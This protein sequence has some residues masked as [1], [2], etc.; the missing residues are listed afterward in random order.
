MST[1]PIYQA[2]LTET[3]RRKLKSGASHLDIG[4]GSG[5]LIQLLQQEC[6]VKSRSCDYTRE[7]MK[8]PG[9]E[10]DIANLNNDPLPYADNT[11]D[12]ITCT[13]VVEHLER[14][15]F[16]VREI[17]RVAKPGGLVIFSTPNILNLR[18]R[19]RFF[20][21][22][23]WNLFGPLPLH[24]NRLDTTGGHINPVSWFYLAHAM[25]DAGLVDVSWSI[26][27]CQRSSYL[28]F[29]LL[30]PLILLGGAWAMYSEETRYNTLDAANEPLVKAI[31]HP[32]MLLGRTILASG[33][34]KSV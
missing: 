17:V 2:V 5:T 14:F 9:I 32:K 3:R 13:E 29:S 30:Y 15:R 19:I 34:K 10:V 8:L 23:F 1:Q 24:H 31:N 27:R 6:G 11:F 4:S 7:L 25:M 21:F 20:C 12:L 33:V 18:S 22:G 26:D 16:I 28:P